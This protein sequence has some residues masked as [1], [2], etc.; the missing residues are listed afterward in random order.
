MR[1]HLKALLAI[2][3]VLSLVCQIQPSTAVA[4]DDSFNVSGYTMSEDY[5]KSVYGSNPADKEENLETK[6]SETKASA[7]VRI[8]NVE[9]KDNVI[10]LYLNMGTGVKNIMLGGEMYAS[11]RTQNGVNCIVVDAKCSNTAYDVLLFEIWNDSDTDKQILYNTALKNTPHVK[12]YLQDS[13]GAI[14][15]FEF[16]LPASLNDLNASDYEKADKA[17]D[18]LWPLKVVDSTV[19]EVPTNDA[20]LEELGLND[21]S[22]EVNTTMLWTDSRTYINTFYIYETQ[23]TSISLPCVKYK[24][25]NVTPQDSTWM[26]SF[27]V[28]EHL[29]ISTPN[30]PNEIYYGDNVFEYRNVKLVFGCGDNS[31]FIRTFQDGRVIDTTK[32]ADSQLVE[33]AGKILIKAIKRAVTQHPT[34][35]YAWDI[36]ETIADI[37]PVDAEV[38]LGERSISLTNGK[39]II[40]GEQLEEKYC[41]A[42]CTDQDGEANV[43]DYFIFQGVLQ[44]ENAG[45]NSSTIGVLSVE[46]DVISK[47]D[48]SQRHR[49]ANITFNYAASA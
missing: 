26:A 21:L 44:Y 36:I 41:F 46:Y 22:R 43:G 29:T 1:K 2:C 30:Y 32:A 16:R 12:L 18:L 14:S 27:T 5:F 3:L 11:A 48:T 19:T 35:V 25:V 37:E 39:T 45:G 20:I 15:M 40:V 17:I 6:N 28:S 47:A 13:A 24:Y 31:T 38:T 42:E 7:D 23:Y 33:T 34:G 9:V 49:S 8:S 10:S 4:Y